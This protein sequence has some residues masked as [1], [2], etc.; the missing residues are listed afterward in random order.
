MR[1][2][3]RRPAYM[4]AAGVV[5]VVIGLSPNAIAQ[6][7]EH[8]VSPQDLSK[9]TQDVTRSRQ[10]NIDN[11]RG[12]FSSAEARK[13]LETAHINPQQVQNAVA[14]LNDEELAQLAARADKA[15]SDFS[16]GTLDNR[17]LLLILVAI[18]ALILIIV[19]VH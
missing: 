9:A 19:A 3:P 1:M 13:A 7:A 8:I 15:H 10:Q 4:L 18:A 6:A 11:L 14:G 17:D 2:N 12:A 16:A 5:S